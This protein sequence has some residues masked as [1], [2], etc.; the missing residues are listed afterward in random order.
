MLLT[1]TGNL[2]SEVVSKRN[3]FNIFHK[4]G[5]LAQISIKQAYGFVQFLEASACYAALNSEQGGR[6]AERNMRE[7]FLR[8][9]IKA[10]SNR[11]RN[12]E[13]TEERAKC[14]T[15]SCWR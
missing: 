11:S 5:R 10:E 3:V 12:L 15:H 4:Y 9:S 6:L 14:T 2:P 13:A 7:C 8:S 1:S